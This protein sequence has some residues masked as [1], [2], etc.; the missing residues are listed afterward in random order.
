MI[1][2]EQ[3]DPISLIA[4]LVMGA[5]KGFALGCTVADSVI[6]SKMEEAAERILRYFFIIYCLFYQVF[7]HT[8]RQPRTGCLRTV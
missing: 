4:S 3:V 2:E 8:A 7:S 1:K 6:A 5:L